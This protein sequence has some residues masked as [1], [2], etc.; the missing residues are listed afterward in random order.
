MYAGTI[1]FLL[2]TAVLEHHPYFKTTRTRSNTQV[3]PVFNQYNIKMVKVVKQVAPSKN[4]TEE[5]LRFAAKRL[6]KK[7]GGLNKGDVKLAV[8]ELYEAL[9]DDHGV[10]EARVG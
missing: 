9:E 6:S 7:Q 5:T 3:E 1:L 4:Y 2:H 8:L 10:L